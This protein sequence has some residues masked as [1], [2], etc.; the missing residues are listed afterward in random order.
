MESRRYRNG[1]ELRPGGA[2]PCR[3][4]AG[5]AAWLQLAARDRG[6]HHPSCSRKPI[7]LPS[8]TL[9]HTRQAGQ[10]FGSL[11][12]NSM[13]PSS[14][15]Y[16]SPPSAML[17]TRP[18]PLADA[19]PPAELTELEWRRQMLAQQQSMTAWIERWVK[20]DELQRWLQFG[21]TLAIPLSAAIWRAILG[22]RRSE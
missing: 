17:R 3:G 5:N 4:W 18:Y 7:P 13:R 11:G 10:S 19:E 9:T 12:V 2:C 20:R 6:A 8:S 22:R 1:R 21:A 15:E 16:A 14:F